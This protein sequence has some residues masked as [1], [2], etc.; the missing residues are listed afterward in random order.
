[1]INNNLSKKASLKNIYL[2]ICGLFTSMIGTKIYYFLIGFI[3]L[4]NTGSSLNF[5][6]SILVGSLPAIIF[7]PIAGWLAD[8]FNKKKILISFD[9][10]SG[11]FMILCFY[12]FPNLSNK[13]L[14]LYF[15]ILIL[16]IFNTFFTV[17]MES[18][19][20][21]IVSKDLLVKI[22][23]YRTIVKS[24]ASILAP[25]LGGLLF[26]FID[27][28]VF[29]LVNGISFLLSAFSEIFLKYRIIK[30]KNDSI[31]FIETFK[32]SIIFIS[33]RR[34][35]FTLI[36]LFTLINFFMSG[37]N[38]LFSVIFINELGLSSKIF[39]TVQSF[40]FFGMFIS[41]IILNKLNTK[42]DLKK[43][44]SINIPLL[45]ICFMFMAIPTNFLFDKSFINIFYF[46]IIVFSVG[47]LIASLD[48]PSRSY[49]QNTVDEKYIGKISGFISSLTQFAMPFGT[50]I[51][52]IALDYFPSYYIAISISI[53]LFVYSLSIYYN[54][55][56][57]N[58]F[59][60]KTKN[61]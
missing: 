38:I 35:I 12:I 1:M 5:A 42:I 22:N 18:S 34:D 13:R 51:F 26:Q 58:K 2:S 24:I 14:F 39:G 8:K 10:L 36:K 31:G 53:S 25:I 21:F 40:L 32:D 46:S 7:S 41:S 6:I 61:I 33:K 55:Y 43:I 57:N 11:L 49:L 54:I 52:G 56:I 37:F 23:S 29:M 16:S 45:T 28:K 44:I 9:I 59:N 50:I 30:V 3:I 4:K 15:S 48:I 17:S 27:L 20:P 47:I 19:T 60:L